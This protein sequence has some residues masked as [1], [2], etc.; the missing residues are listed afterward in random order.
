MS[1]L[2]GNRGP[3]GTM[4]EKIPSGY[5]KSSINQFTP[6]Q[7]Q[8]LS[9]LYP[10]LAE[11]SYLSRLASGD[12]SFFAE[13]EAPAF[14]QLAE[15]QGG[16]ASRFSGMGLGAR[17]SSGFQNAA[18]AQ[19][20]DLALQLQGQRQ[21]LQRQAIQDLMGHSAVLLGQRPYESGLVQKPQQQALGGWGGV[22]GTGLGLV[23]S[24]ATGMDPLKGA[25]LGNK[26][27]SGL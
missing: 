23:G 9:S 13:Q 11:G 12:Q 22:I 3:T 7:H 20:S 17:R 25:E 19:A 24:Y 2:T 27:L 18:G 10:H 5:S 16:L 6:E 21:N 15:L 8:L 26:T 1:S 4:K 14:R